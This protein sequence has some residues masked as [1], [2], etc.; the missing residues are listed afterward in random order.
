MPGPIVEA[1][2]QLLTYWPFA[3]AGFALMIAPIRVLKF[4]AA[5][6]QYIRSCVLASTMGPGVKVAATKL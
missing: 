3:A 5:K 2:V 6:G 4:S 1:T